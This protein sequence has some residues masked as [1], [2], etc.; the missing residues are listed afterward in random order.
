MIPAPQALKDLLATGSFAKADLYTFSLI[1]GSLLRWTAADIDVVAAGRLFSSSG[2][3]FERGTT[4]TVIGLEVDELTITV[5]ADE[6]VTINGVPFMEFVCKG[7]FDGA[8]VLL[9][10]AFM[11]DW[12]SPV[13]GTVVQFFGR[14]APIEGGWPKATLKVKSW[15]EV[16][17]TKLPRN[18]YQ[19]A[20]MLRLYGNR[21]GVVRT[22]FAANG[23]AGAGATMS[24]IPCDLSQAAGWFDLGVVEFTSG[25][26]EGV[27]RTVRSYQPGR[28]VMA[29][30]FPSVPEAGDTF[31]AYPGCHRLVPSLVNQSLVTTIPASR[32][33]AVSSPAA[34]DDDRGVTLIGLTHSNP[35][36]WDP[37]A[38][39]VDGGSTK[40]SDVSLVKVST[41]PAQGQYAIAGNVY[42][43]AAAD[44]GRQIVLNWREGA[45]SADCFVKYRNAGHFRGTPYVPVAETAR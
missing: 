20:C 17:D 18:V 45:G 30:P 33:I 19:P 35:G 42:A 28:L 5:S 7:G 26:N 24:S 15:I 34:F 23:I 39:W 44:V 41:P 10:R 25:A 1:G 2:P 22:A 8:T 32:A 11:P 12:N 9:E 4:R 14:M 3:K 29:L 40:D 13:T 36:Y 21:C 38:G 37:D 27:K 43:F 6:T 31:V 16:L